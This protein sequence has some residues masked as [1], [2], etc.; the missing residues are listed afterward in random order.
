M[1]SG[2]PDGLVRDLMPLLRRL[3]AGEYGIAVGGSR[4]KGIGDDQS[5]VDIY[6][7]M[8]ETFPAD[9]RRAWT[10]A[11]LGPAAQVVSWDRAAPFVEGGTD[12]SYGGHKVETWLRGVRAV[13]ATLAACQAGQIR[14]DC[15]AW[16]VMGFYNYVV[17]SDIHGMQVVED[18]YGILARWKAQIATY[19]RPLREAIV[20]RYLHEAQFWPE[21]FHY[22][23]A[24]ERAD[25]IYTAGIVQQVLYALIQVLF[26]LNEVYF[27]GEKKLAVTLEKL[28]VK[29]PA[30]ARRVQELMYPGQSPNVEHLRAQR[31][32][33]SALVSEVVRLAG[34]VAIA[35]LTR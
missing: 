13:E 34:A 1:H 9:Q 19:P 30:F 5:D 23:S 4:V 32:A 18:P 7:F 21:N 11:A 14:R 31:T 6:L 16:T 15:I 33:L 25:I 8:A 35:G 10:E 2:M 20:G 28:K 24:V 17:L 22:L 26:A 29:P 12:F 3:C 27:P